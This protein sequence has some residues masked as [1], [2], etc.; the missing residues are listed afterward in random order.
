M[1]RT[2]REDSEYQKLEV[3]LELSTK[4]FQG[5]CFIVVLKYCANLVNTFVHFFGFHLLIE[6]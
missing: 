1:D 2:D 6:F 3:R 5:K 4:A